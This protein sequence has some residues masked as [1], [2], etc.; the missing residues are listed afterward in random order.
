MAFKMNGSP[1]RLGT[2]QGTAGHA[3]ALKLMKE[4]KPAPT[5]AMKED[6]PA[7]TKAMEKDKSAPTKLRPSYETKY[8][9]DKEGK[10]TKTKRMVSDSY[11][12]EAEKAG[13]HITRTGMSEYKHQMKRYDKKG[14]SKKRASE[15]GVFE[16]YIKQDASKS[17]PKTATATKIRAEK[18]LKASKSDPKVIAEEK[19]QAKHKNFGKELKESIKMRNIKENRRTTDKRDEVD[20]RY[21]EATAAQSKRK[22]DARNK[23]MIK[24][25][26]NKAAQEKDRKKYEVKK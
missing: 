17:K 19:K 4:D 2:I 1:A 14:G 5:K 23:K 7:P 24:A 11:A 16:R 6:K 10:Q 20:K 15:G 25:K 26:Q 12:D 13:K 18:A 21:E 9:V 22:Q 8:G 3:S